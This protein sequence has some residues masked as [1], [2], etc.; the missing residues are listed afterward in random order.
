MDGPTEQMPV[1]YYKNRYKWED[2]SVSK[3]ECHFYSHGQPMNMED[4]NS[5][6]VK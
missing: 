6:G 4:Y 3:V 1:Y 5:G 2:Q